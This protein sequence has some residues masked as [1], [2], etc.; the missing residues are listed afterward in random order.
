MSV[1]DTTAGAAALFSRGRRMSHA[2]PPPSGATISVVIPTLDE[3][4]N[5]PHVMARIPAIV[6]EVI[7]VDGHSRDATIDV[8]RTIRPD[9]RVG[10][11]DGRGKGAAPRSEK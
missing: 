8:A 7:L 9:V 5:L 2:A 1:T 3:A 4:A 6:D 11:Q 10:L